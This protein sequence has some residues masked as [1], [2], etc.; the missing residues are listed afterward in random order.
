MSWYSSFYFT[1]RSTAWYGIS[2]AFYTAL[3]GALAL[4]LMAPLVVQLKTKAPGARTFLQVIYARFGKWP[5]LLFCFIAFSINVTALLALLTR[6]TTGL[7]Q[8]ASVTS[9]EIVLAVFIFVVG[10]GLTYGGISGI[11]TTTYI[12]VGF[13]LWF[14]LILGCSF[15]NIYDLINC[16]IGPV[17]NYNRSFLTF[18]SRASALSTIEDFGMSLVYT[19]MDQSYW[20]AIFNSDPESGGFSLLAAALIWFPMPAVFGTACGLGYLAL[21]MAY[22]MVQLSPD[23]EKMGADYGFSL[24]IQQVRDMYVTSLNIFYWSAVGPNA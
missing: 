13:Y 9:E 11:Y 14:T 5:H 22:G 16:Q 12:Y 20:Q 4:S 6:A 23:M 8:N 7:I 3:A 18:R 24:D 2:G 1:S 19:V 21:N 10:L 17:G 15:E